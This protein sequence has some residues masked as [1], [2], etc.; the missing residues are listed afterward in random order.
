MITTGKSTKH[1]HYTRPNQQGHFSE[2]GLIQSVCPWKKGTEI[3]LPIMM[4]AGQ[5]KCPTSHQIPLKTNRSLLKRF[6][7][8]VT[9]P[10]NNWCT[11]LC[12]PIISRTGS[13][14]TPPPHSGL[15]GSCIH[16]TRKH[17]DIVLST[18]LHDMDTVALFKSFTLMGKQ[19]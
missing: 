18:W 12:P 2:F 16:Q 5:F 11:R 13:A 1:T 6:S 4:K 19:Q 9:M 10:W 14:P 3:C 15:C 7:F 17:S 8:E